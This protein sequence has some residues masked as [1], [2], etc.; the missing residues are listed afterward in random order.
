M[1][2]FFSKQRHRRRQWKNFNV[3]AS[4]PKLCFSFDKAGSELVP[5]LVLVCIACVV[6]II[7]GHSSSSYNS[8]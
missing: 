5:R 3:L 4:A 7:T 2:S 8:N 6:I 1:E